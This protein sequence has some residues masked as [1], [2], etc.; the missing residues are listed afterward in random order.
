LI[1]GVAPDPAADQPTRRVGGISA[2]TITAFIAPGANF[3]KTR[4]LAALSDARNGGGRR[5]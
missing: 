1:A 3:P 2:R 5:V 4:L